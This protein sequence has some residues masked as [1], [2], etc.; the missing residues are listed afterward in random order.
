MVSNAFSASLARRRTLIMVLK[1]L[2]KMTL[3]TGVIYFCIGDKLNQDTLNQARQL[4]I[5]WLLAAI[6]IY[7]IHIL[8]FSW[9]WRIIALLQRISISNFKALSL[10]MQGVFFALVIPGGAVGG[11]VAKIG[12]FCNQSEKKRLEGAFSILMD[13]IVGMIALFVLTL[14]LLPFSSKLFSAITLP[15]M[16][17]GVKVDHILL[18][19]LLLL[20]LA[21]LGACVIIFFHKIWL[22]IPLLNSL[23]NKFDAVTH[24][25]FERMCNATDR[26][27]TQ[28]KTLM[29]MTVI[30]LF[31]VH[32]FTALA[33]CC[34]LSGLQVEYSLFTVIVGMTVGNI[35]GMIPLFPS[36]VGIRDVVVVAFLVAGGISLESAGLA[37]LIY[38]AIILFYSLLGGVFF[39]FDNPKRISATP[40]TA[41]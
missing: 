20:C 19:G 27:A 21:G 22:K 5:F 37:Q 34:L 15:A 11:D 4:N 32:I 33:L 26:Y 16:L 31:F 14:L 40:A 17:G 10:S 3:A 23:L 41:I 9:R 18:P 7:G 35:M 28:W 13:R 8:V 24:G 1:S 12:L 38:T 30:S 39:V 36:G 6:V 2:L 29:A 25:S